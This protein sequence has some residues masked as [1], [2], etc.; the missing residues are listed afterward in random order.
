[1]YGWMH[2]VDTKWLIQKQHMVETVLGYLLG[3]LPPWTEIYPLPNLL[4]FLLG[5]G[6]TEKL[7]YRILGLNGK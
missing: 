4:Y 5:E 3:H 7:D 6:F 2:T 1:M